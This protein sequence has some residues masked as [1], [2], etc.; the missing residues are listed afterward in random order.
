MNI[1][2]DEKTMVLKK[3]CENIVN[4]EPNEL[5]TLSFQ[6]FSMCTNAAQVITPI[7]SLNHYFHRN[8]YKKVFGNLCSEQSNVDS[9]GEK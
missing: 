6:L 3:L 8:Y 7:F 5:P 9:I 1:S 2:K 4:L